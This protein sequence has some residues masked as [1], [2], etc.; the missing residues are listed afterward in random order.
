ME[1]WYVWRASLPRGPPN[2]QAKWSTLLHPCT[3]VLCAYYMPLRGAGR[4]CARVLACQP[5]SACGVPRDVVI[6]VDGP[7][8][9][10]CRQ[11][12]AAGPGFPHPARTATGEG[13]N[14]PPIT[15]GISPTPVVLSA[16]LR[17][18]RGPDDIP[19]R[20]IARI[21]GTADM[22]H[23]CIVY[24]RLAWADTAK[25]PSGRMPYIV[26]HSATR[27]SSSPLWLPHTQSA[28]SSPAFGCPDNQDLATKYMPPP[29]PYVPHTCRDALVPPPSQRRL[30]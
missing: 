4:A 21:M 16:G 19:S 3:F 5:R 23:A 7:G 24:G 2:L 25:S 15:S 9:G 1:S 8:A 26:P 6:S 17:G 13:H 18:G 11:H 29:L 30:L 22:L 14:G 20:A 10:R 27:Q 28:S 12:Y